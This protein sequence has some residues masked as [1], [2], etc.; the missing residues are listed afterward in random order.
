MIKVIKLSDLNNCWSAAR[1]A[2]SC[3]PCKRYDTCTYPERQ[4][5]IAYQHN[6]QERSLVAAR[7]NELDAAAKHIS[8]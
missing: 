1:L 3:L 7:L 6:R 8:I 2:N 4:F 5:H